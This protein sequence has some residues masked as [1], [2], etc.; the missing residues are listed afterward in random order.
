MD[1]RT[2]VVQA[3][4]SLPTMTIDYPLSGLPSPAPRLSYLRYGVL[5]I[6]IKVYVVRLMCAATLTRMQVA[7]APQSYTYQVSRIQT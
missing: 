5:P 7:R 2:L 6:R 3:C 1:P 4:A